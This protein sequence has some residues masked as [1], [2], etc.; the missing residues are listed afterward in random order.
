MEAAQVKEISRQI[1]EL[2]PDDPQLAISV[3]ALNFANVVVATGAD[4]ETAIHSLR[5]ALKQMRNGTWWFDA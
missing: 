1:N 4:D 3:C 5:I 2:L